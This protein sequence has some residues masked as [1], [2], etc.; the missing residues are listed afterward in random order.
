MKKTKAQILKEKYGVNR[1]K[2]LNDEDLNE[3]NK[4]KQI[5]SGKDYIFNRDKSFKKFYG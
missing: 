3:I 5:K 1:N 2:N 4:K